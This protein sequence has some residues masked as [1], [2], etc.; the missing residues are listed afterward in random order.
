MSVKAMAWAWAQEN[1]S[2]GEKLLLMA[3]AD[4]ADDEGVCWPGQVGLANKC[5]ISDRTVRTRLKKLET[6]GLLAR[7]PRYNAEGKRTSDRI[8][9][10]FTTG[11]L[12]HRKTLPPER[13]AS[14]EPSGTTVPSTRVSTTS[15]GN[16]SST[17]SV[18]TA[19]PTQPSTSTTPPLKVDGLRLTAGEWE[20]AQ[21]ILHEFNQQVGTRF[22]LVGSR[23]RPTEHLKRI[24]GRLRE[25]PEVPL[26]RHLEVIRHT[27]EN[28]W[29]GQT[30]PT[31]VGVIYGQRAFL[32]C[33]AMEPPAKNF[34]DERAPSP[35]G[36]P[37]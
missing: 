22:S 16:S 11:K 12:C 10:R 2:E 15:E 30:T 27:C 37:W 32:R 26:S 24:V 34:A 19:N 3:V 1:L 14:R 8:T 17:G 29:W 7:E 21:A 4:H 13:A 31:S 28:P 33:L 18:P 36:S 35:E 25:N 23:G 20:M 9:L 6:L 5:G